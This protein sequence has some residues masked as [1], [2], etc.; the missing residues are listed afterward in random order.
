MSV[1][2]FVDTN[3]WVYAHLDQAYDSKGGMASALVESGRRFVISTQIL[4]EYYAAMLRNR[5]DDSW[6]QTNVEAMIQR[7]DVC[8]ITLAIIRQAQALK[9]RYGFSYWDSLVI[10]SALEA[11]SQIFYSEDLQHGQQIDGRLHIINPFVAKSLVIKEI[12]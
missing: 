10:A 2:P 3:I 7:C 4:N 12:S 11:G 9:V 5:M 6:I 8:L 1:E